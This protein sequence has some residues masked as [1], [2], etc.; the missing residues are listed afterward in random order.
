MKAVNRSSCL[1]GSLGSRVRG[2][3]GF[4]GE[5]PWGAGAG[6]SRGHARATRPAAE[7]GPRGALRPQGALRGAAGPGPCRYRGPRRPE[8][9]PGGSPTPLGVPSHPRT[10][11]PQGANASLHRGADRVGSTEPRR[12]T[13]LPAQCPT[14]LTCCPGLRLMVTSEAW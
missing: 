5:G 11:R 8:R 1:R 7:R 2:F 12:V 3:N 4:F 6:Q 9:L 13:A 10:A 14:L